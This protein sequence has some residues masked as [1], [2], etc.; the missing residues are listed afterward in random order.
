MVSNRKVVANLIQKNE[1][2]IVFKE[3]NPKEMARLVKQAFSDEK[4]YKTWKE[5]LVKAAEKYNWENESIKLKEIYTN[6]N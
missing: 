6:L 1:I 4:Q 5:N 2:G 3:H